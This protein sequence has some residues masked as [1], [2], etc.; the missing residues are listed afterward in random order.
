MISIPR[1]ATCCGFSLLMLSNA[2]GQATCP[3][4]NWSRPAL[5][6]LQAA[7]WVVENPAQRETLAMGLLACLADP[8]P[9]LR[10][11]IA[12][13]ALSAWMR[14]KLLPMDLQRRMYS[15]L[16]GQLQ[17]NVG[18]EAGFAQP[19]AALT[20]AEIARSDGAT[21]FLTESERN[22]LVDAATTYLRGVRDYRGFIQG[23][24]WRHGVAHGADLLMQLARNPLVGKEQL[25]R[26][27]EAVQS[28]V[29]PNASHFYVYGES[30]RLA[31]PVLFAAR[32]GLI[33]PEWWLHIIE[34]ISA[35]KPLTRWEQALGTQAGLSRL[36]NTKAFLLGLFA[37]VRESPDEGLQAALLTPLRRALEQLP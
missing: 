11:G 6:Q 33:E 32:R 16:L 21:P 17:S 22:A 20:L 25:K 13:E 36:H 26:I 5:T 37:N 19:F 7:K 8:D 2:W 4:A 29:V 30:E 28:Q 27:V 23:E 9:V 35:P 1:I 31:R 18:S 34:G 3:P 12:F 14:Q 24:G 15:Q 10:D